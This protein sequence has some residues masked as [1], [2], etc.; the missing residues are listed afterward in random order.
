MKYKEKIKKNPKN[1]IIKNN[2]I[3]YYSQFFQKWFIQLRVYKFNILFYGV[4]SKK[5]IIETFAKKCLIDGPLFIINGYD[6]F[7]YKIEVLYKLK[8]CILNKKNV[9]LNKDII[10]ES[11]NLISLIKEDNHYYIVM[12]NID[13]E[14]YSKNKLIQKSL[15]ILLSNK[16]IHFITS[17]DNINSMFLFDKNILT[18][19]RFIYNE[20]T[21]YKHYFYETEN[22]KKILKSLSKNNTLRAK[23]I[24]HILK[25]LNDGQID[26]LIK[27]GE[28]QVYESKSNGISRIEWFNLCQDSM[29]VSNEITFRGFETQLKDHNLIKIINKNGESLTKIPYNND[30]IER[31][32]LNF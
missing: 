29:L 27:L 12:N 30:I 17:F 23:G 16:N 22:N 26:C 21:T 8:Q 2:L 9:K 3:K 20:I 6:S 15:L 11:N 31:E 1:K 19:Y 32:I 18:K 25:S 10:V 24:K 4:G 14:Y 5:N 7:D 13:G 28:Q